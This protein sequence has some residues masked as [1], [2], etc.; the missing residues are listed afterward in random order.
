MIFPKAFSTKCRCLY[1]WRSY[2][3]CTKRFLFG[4]MTGSAP[5]ALTASRQASES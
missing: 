1:T 2:G 5:Q 4:G 3:L